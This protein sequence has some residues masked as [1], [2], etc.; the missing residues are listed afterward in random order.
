[1]DKSNYRFSVFDYDLDAEAEER[2]TRLHRESIVI[3][4]LF[5][6]PSTKQSITPEME[7]ELIDLLQA[8]G[9]VNEVTLR[10]LFQAQQK[11][12]NGEFPRFKEDW[13]ASGITAGNRT[14]EFSSWEAFALSMAYQIALFDRVDWVEK[15]LT[16]ADIRRAKSENKHAAW[17]NTQLATGI[18]EN[19][20]DLL[21][22]AHMM[23]LRMVM[24]TYNLGN[25]IGAG[26][27]ERT[28][29]GIS[30]YGA[31]CI[32]RMNEL[33]IIVDTGHCGRQTTLDACEL[34]T[35]PVIASHTAA[36]KVYD[37]TRAKTD[38]EIK[39]LADT[40]GIIGV[41]N[42]PFFIAPLAMGDKKIGMNEWLDQIEYIV[43]LVG[44]EHVGIGT[45]W[46]M[47]LPD[48]IL[49]EAFL[50][51]S[52]KRGFDAQR[53]RLSEMMTP[54]DG[55]VD[56]RDFPNVTRGLVKRGYSDKQIKGILGENFL[57]VFETVCG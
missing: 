49:L 23:G 39:A 48:S 52:L 33:G 22:P 29:A 6:G 25:L 20:I 13:D 19:F 53:D 12:V 50:P 30:N 24:L 36:K 56:Y 27:T 31:S 11:A 8:T 2:A 35:Q 47:S 1:M 38:E 45:D 43:N 55:F 54:L 4:M 26:C 40:G 57:R 10:G 9:D 18:T 37:H 42:L 51:G 16:A 15:A 34:S 41:Y 14:T 28:D 46:P 3:D 44:W 32:A 5:W 17:I 21:E 7:Q